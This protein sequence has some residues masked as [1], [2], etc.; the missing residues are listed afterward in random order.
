MDRVTAL[1][2]TLTEISLDGPMTKR[3]YTDAIDD[4]RKQFSEEVAL[5]RLQLERQGSP[6]EHGANSGQRLFNPKDV[7]PDTLSTDYK[8]RWR[9]W[10]YKARD[11]LSLVEE[12]LGPKLASVEG[13]TTELTPEAISAMNISDRADAAIKRFLVHRLDGDPAEV[14][15]NSANKAGIEQYRCLAQLCD[16]SVEGRNWADA[17]HLY[18]PTPAGSVQ[19]IPAKLAE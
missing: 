19:A 6:T 10:A 1:E 14:V 9:V 16:P 13:M 3:E 8:A 12:S 2:R 5:L 17:Q 18:S 7:M 4:V 15:R 11:W